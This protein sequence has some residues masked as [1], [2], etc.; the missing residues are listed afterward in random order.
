MRSTGKGRIRIC[1][2]RSTTSTDLRVC[3]PEVHHPGSALVDLVD[4]VDLLQPIR[5]GVS[6]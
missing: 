4:L 6:G 1:G 2:R 5:K 3:E